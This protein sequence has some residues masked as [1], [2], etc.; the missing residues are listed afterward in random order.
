MR[1]KKIATTRVDYGHRRVHV[2]LRR[3]GWRDNIKRIYRLYQQEGWLLRCKHPKRNKSA[4]LRQPK[5]LVTAINQIWSMDFV[6]DTL[7]DGRRL[8]ALTVVDNYIRESLAIDVGQSL[9]GEEVVKTLNRITA[10]RGSPATIMVDNG[11]E[12]IFKAM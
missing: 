7:F 8:R 9:K 3:E 5:D 11:S 6:A 1:I 4:P 10:R 12:F 2:V